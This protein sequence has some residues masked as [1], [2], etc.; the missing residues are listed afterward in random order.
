[1]RDLLF[2]LDVQGIGQKPYKSLTE[3][4]Y[5]KGL[6][7]STELFENGWHIGIRANKETIIYG[8]L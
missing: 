1:M 7:L 4:E 2:G 8:Y 3:L 5:R 6:R